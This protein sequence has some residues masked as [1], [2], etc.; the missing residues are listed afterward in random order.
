MNKAQGLE[1]LGLNSGKITLLV[2][3]G[4]LGAKAINEAID[5]HLDTI[6]SWDVQLLWQTGTP[7]F[8]RAKERTKD[9]PAQVKVMEFIREMNAAYAACDVVVSRAGALSIAELCIVGKP[10]VFVPYPFAAEDHQTS[11]AMALVNKNAALMVS[12]SEVMEQLLPKLQSLIDNVEMRDVMETNLKSMAIVDA[13]TRIANKIIE[14]ATQ[15]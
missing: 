4:S 13:D 5:K 3:G 14:I 6:L 8:E 15:H 1:W 10:V 2:V 9:K 12:N 11:N 7:Y